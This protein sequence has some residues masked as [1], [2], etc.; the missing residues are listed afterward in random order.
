MYLIFSDKVKEVW[1]LISTPPTH[2]HELVNVTRGKYS[3]RFFYYG[4]RSGKG[5]TAELSALDSSVVKMSNPTNLAQKSCVLCTNIRLES[6]CTE[7]PADAYFLSFRPLIAEYQ[8]ATTY[9][10]IRSYKYSA[11]F[12][13]TSTDPELKC[14]CRTPTTCLKKGVHDISRCAGENCCN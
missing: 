14:Y 2:H 1:S 6:P 4:L 9:R 3:L 13:D 8:Y 11:D 10:G 12:G 5:N 7:R